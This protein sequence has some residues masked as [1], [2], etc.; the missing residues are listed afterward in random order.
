MWNSIYSE[1][2]ERLRAILLAARKGAGLTQEE[3][4]ARIGAYRTF[5]SKY[6]KGDRQIRVIEFIALAE[7]MGLDPVEMLRELR[8]PASSR[9]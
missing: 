9:S 6:E 5:V 7:A 2:N 3:L 1:R 8:R 4:C